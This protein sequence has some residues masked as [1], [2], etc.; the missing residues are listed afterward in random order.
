[1]TA[2][3]TAL[4]SLSS[5]NSGA[6]PRQTSGSHSLGSTSSGP[7]AMVGHQE[8]VERLQID[9]LDGNRMSQ[10]LGAHRGLANR[11]NGI[12]A[13]GE[14]AV[15]PPA[16]AIHT[17]NDA[18]R[19][20]ILLEVA[21]LDALLVLFFDKATGNPM[22][23]QGPYAANCW[24]G[25]DLGGKRLDAQLLAPPPEQPRGFEKIRAVIMAVA[26]G[27]NGQS[28]QPGHA[29]VNGSEPSN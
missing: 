29:G 11:C 5:A 4:A 12:M 3:R 16:G 19:R 28:G 2:P 25:L 13:C 23:P 6:S 7:T 24:N 8:A 1:M 26:R 21:R 22:L 15:R 10:G 9:L 18:R 20:A 14:V 27:G 17:N